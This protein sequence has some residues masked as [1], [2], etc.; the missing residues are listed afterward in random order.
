MWHK[1]LHLHKENTT[2]EK[3]FS[4]ISDSSVHS[5]FITFCIVLQNGRN[6]SVVNFSFRF[7]WWWNFNTF[8]LCFWIHKVERTYIWFLCMLDIPCHHFCHS[9]DILMTFIFSSPDGLNPV[10]IAMNLVLQH[11]S[12]FVFSLLSSVNLGIPEDILF[13]YDCIIT[14]SIKY[15]DT[16]QSRTSALCDNHH[17]PVNSSCGTKLIS[18]VFC[19]HFQFP[20]FS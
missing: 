20:L 19:F 8:W 2:Y 14:C 13:W 11:S 6:I 17:F 15:C 10:Y 9:S 12:L 5:L 18:V 3:L 16:I 4:I 1:V 7:S